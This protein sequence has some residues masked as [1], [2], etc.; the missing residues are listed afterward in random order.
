MDLTVRQEEANLVFWFRSPLSVKHAILAWYVP[1][2][3]TDSKTRNIVYS[4]D[5]ANLSL[6]IDGKKRARAYT[7]SGLAQHW[8]GSC[9]GS[10][11]P[12]WKATVDIYCFLVFFPVGIILGIAAQTNLE[13]NGNLV[14][15]VVLGCSRFS[16]RIDSCAR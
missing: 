8:H 3:F 12:S 11:P 10:V 9:A 7:I 14:T 16:S 13:R 5:G 6:Y 15:R 2:V 4:Y 1:N